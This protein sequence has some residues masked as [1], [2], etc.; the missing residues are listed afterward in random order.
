MKK[1]I[2]NS[3]IIGLLSTLLLSGC[4]KEETKQA[5][6]PSLP[7]VKSLTLNPQPITPHLEFIGRTSSVSSVEIIPRVGGE[8]KAIHF[9][10]GDFVKK[11]DLLY[12]IDPRI[13]H[14]AV[15]SAK[16][17]LEKARATL[18]MTTSNAERAKQL[19]KDKSISVQ[20]Y[21]TAIANYESAKADISE[22]QATLKSAQLDLEFSRIYAPFSGRL[23]FSRYKVGEQ[24]TA[25]LPPSSTMKNSLVSLTKVN[26]INFDFNVD[27]KVY[28][29]IRSA[30]DVVRNEN[31]KL[32]LDIRLTLSDG[33]EYAKNGKIAAVGNKIDPS[34]GSI[35]VRAIFDNTDYSLMP[36][37]FGKIKIG[38][39]ERTVNGLLIPKSS[40]QQDQAGNYVMQLTKKNIVKQQ[41]V[42]LG[43]V[44]GTNKA[45]ISGL[46]SGDRIVT[47]GLQKIR[48]GIQVE[49]ITP[50]K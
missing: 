7:K 40:I 8:L 46:N 22:K 10:D 49:E 21:D 43:Q 29:R 15:N 9:K 6:T 28:R 31:K 50:E 11:G 20:Q 38:L 4:N 32:N 25:L 14:A 24:I 27:E 37:E 1:I 2:A 26:V 39:K 5:V 23:G 41:Y 18:K 33:S 42:I 45:V 35:H 48:P 30:I 19:I 13:F 44:Y 3:L 17:S 34:T 12:E 16:A 36:G 47:E